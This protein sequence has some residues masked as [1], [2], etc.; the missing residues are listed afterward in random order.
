MVVDSQESLGPHLVK[1]CLGMDFLDSFIGDSQSFLKQRNVHSSF[2]I[3]TFEDLTGKNAPLQ[4]VDVQEEIDQD[5][6]SI[7]KP[8]KE[9]FGETIKESYRNK[10]CKSK[11]ENFNRGSYKW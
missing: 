7:Q 9:S 6:T 1:G 5:I 3:P 11:R 8:M 2:V 10:H 4:D